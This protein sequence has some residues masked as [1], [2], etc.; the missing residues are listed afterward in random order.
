MGYAAEHRADV[1]SGDDEVSH[2]AHLPLLP[3]KTR[4]IRCYPP[5]RHQ[6]KP[7]SAACLRPVLFS[8]CAWAKTAAWVLAQ[9]RVQAALDGRGDSHRAFGGRYRRDGDPSRMRRI[10]SGQALQ[11]PSKLRMSA[12]KQL[13]ARKLAARVER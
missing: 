1:F 8:I 7:A 6:Q 3:G 13:K 5:T 9:M 2:L 12:A 11:A 10:I 4:V